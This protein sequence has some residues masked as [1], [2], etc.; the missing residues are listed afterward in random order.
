MGT[1]TQYT[2]FTE[3]E[4]EFA[5]EHCYMIEG[6][7]RKKGYPIDDWYDVVVFRYLLSV[8]N[9]F[10]RPELR[11]LSFGTIAYK[12]MWSAIGN[13]LKKRSNRIQPISLDAELPDSDGAC[14][15][16]TVTVDN[17]N[18]IYVEKEN[19]MKINYNVELP[20]KRRIGVKSDEII[21]LESFLITKSKN[22]CFEYDTVEEAKKKAPIVQGY[23]KKMGHQNMYEVFRSE[24]KLYVVKNGGKA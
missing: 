22:M 19:Q 17:L 4:Q 11:K 2:P 14:L 3:Q 1:R 20:E 23:R 10:N 9:W 15:M 6:F 8:K 18:Y 13:E 21:A 7:L 16:D 12:A 5:A 24:N